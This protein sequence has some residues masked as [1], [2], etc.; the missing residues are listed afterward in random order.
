MIALII[1]AGAVWQN[2]KL[3]N[4][5]RAEAQL[6][7]QPQQEEV[8]QE[9]INIVNP[10]VADN[11]LKDR[12]IFAETGSYVVAKKVSGAIANMPFALLGILSGKE[13][14]AVIRD[15]QGEVTFSSTGKKVGKY[16][17]T[18]IDST[19]V[20]LKSENE[21]KELKIFNVPYKP[22]KR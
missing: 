20:I 6:P 11:I 7:R 22:P 4:A 2:M 13:R 15:D 14:K 16:I 5:L 1:T 17:V 10:V 21:T 3:N 8:K 18:R 19:S 12:N 9:Q